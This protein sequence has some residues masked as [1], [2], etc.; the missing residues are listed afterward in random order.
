MAS[1]LYMAWTSGS[2]DGT[3]SREYYSKAVQAMKSQVG[4]REKCSDDEILMAVLLLQMYEV[5][6]IGFQTHGGLFTD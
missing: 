5:S 4:Q 3:L 1:A 6:E 2:L